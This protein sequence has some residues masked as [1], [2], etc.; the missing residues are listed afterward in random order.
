MARPKVS[1]DLKRAINFT[2]RLTGQERLRLRAAAELCSL[3]PGA[4]IRRKIFQGKFPQPRLSRVDTQA[5]LELKKIGVNL[6]Q[7][8]RLAHT[9]RVGRELLKTLLNLHLQQ[10]RIIQKLLGHGSD[11]EDR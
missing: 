7:L 3:S 8:T 10:E 2:L 1:N 11:P 5:Y 4:F 9:G 6:N